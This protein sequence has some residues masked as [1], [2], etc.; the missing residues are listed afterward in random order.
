MGAL[1]PVVA[2]LTLL[3]GTGRPVGKAIADRKT[4]D[5]SAYPDLVVIYLGMRVNRLT[6]WKTLLGFGPKISKAAA[7]KP[8]GL[9][10]HEPIIYSLRH[11]G[12]RQYWRDF[13]SLER[14]ARTQPHQAWWQAFILNTGG[15]GFWHET[16]FLKGGMESVYDDMETPVGFLRFATRKPARGAMFTARK[17]MGF[18]TPDTVPVPVGEDELYSS[19]TQS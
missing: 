12:M 7:T 8:D 9:L 19:Q 5:L 6:G 16:Y 1:L 14:W 18:Q 11:I 10:L 17:R 13:D 2:I 3:S 15:T 4:A